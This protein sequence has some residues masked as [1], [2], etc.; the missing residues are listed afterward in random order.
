MPN[1]EQVGKTSTFPKL[2]L[3]TAYNVV[4]ISDSKLEDFQTL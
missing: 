4:P 3:K 1:I 2:D